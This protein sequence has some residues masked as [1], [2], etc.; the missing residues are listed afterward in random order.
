MSVRLEPGLLMGVMAE[1][2]TDGV[3]VD[4]RK[5]DVIRVAPAPLYNNYTE[6]WDFVKIFKAAC[7][8]VK[9]GKAPN[10]NASVSVEVGKDAKGWSQ[11]E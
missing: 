2:E 5:P 9:S 7:E 10:G 11:I 4:Q 1:L 8:K 3:V 6:V